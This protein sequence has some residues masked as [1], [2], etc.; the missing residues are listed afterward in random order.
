MIL[1]FTLLS[2]ATAPLCLGFCKND[3]ATLYRLASCLNTEAKGNA[4]IG[5]SLMKNCHEILLGKEIIKSC[6]AVN[7]TRVPICYLHKADPSYDE[8]L[9]SIKMLCAVSIAR[10]DDHVQKTG[11]SFEIPW[12]MYVMVLC[13]M[14]CALTYVV[15]GVFL[16][17]RGFSRVSL[18]PSEQS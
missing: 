17:R 12:G 10:P 13:F 3:L 7:I 4:D 1:L 18:T 14:F 5:L 15:H 16:T 11:E 8:C 9:D 6:K 2:C